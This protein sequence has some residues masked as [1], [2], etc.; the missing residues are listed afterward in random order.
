LTDVDLLPWWATLPQSMVGSPEVTPISPAKRTGWLIPSLFYMETKHVHHHSGA[1]TP[2]LDLLICSVFVKMG[3]TPNRVT[4]SSM[5][6][7]NVMML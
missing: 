1:T 2:F 6:A 5:K 7:Q 4:E 3:D